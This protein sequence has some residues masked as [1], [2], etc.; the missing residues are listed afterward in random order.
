VT[1][2]PLPWSLVALVAAVGCSH[3]EAPARTAHPGRARFTLLTYNVNY[4]LAGDPA[5]LALVRQESPD[6]VLLQET[7]PEWESA[8]RAAFAADYPEIRFRHCCGAG[9]M[10]VLSKYPI[11]LDVPL[12][13]PERG[14]FP[15]WR[16]V[17]DGP[18]GKL[19]ALNVHLHPQLSES[20][21]VTGVFT[22]QPIRRAE[23]EKYA[24]ELDPAI[25]TLIAGDFNEGQRGAAL[26]LLGSRGYDDALHEFHGSQP[27]WHWPTSVGTLSA[28]FDHVTHDARLVPLE[29]HVVQGGRFVSANA[30]EVVGEWTV[31]PEHLQP[32]G[33]IHGGVYAGLVETVCST[34]AAI[35][36]FARE[37]TVVGV[38]NHTTFVRATR[39]GTLRV[40][41]TPLTRGRRTQVWDAVVRNQDGQTVASGRVRLI[42][43]ESGAALAGETVAVKG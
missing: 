18:R 15:A 14:W 22:T 35:F 16:L 37:Q 40:T 12:E 38:D 39:E 9:G 20:G 28:Q 24:A 32:Y 29:A 33:I 31:G 17:L 21:S 3:A 42:C 25:P 30:D 43:L 27:T 10:G 1:P 41:A 2:K 19:Q 13:P 11:S 4:G 5:A 34:G 6:L 23:I 26:A 8:F 36:A 7:T